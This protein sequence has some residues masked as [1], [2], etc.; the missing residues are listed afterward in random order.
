MKNTLLSFGLAGIT[1]AL[2]SFTFIQKSDEVQEP[3]TK[4]HIKMMKMENGKKMELDTVLNNDDVFV[5][6]GDTINPI[7]HLKKVNPS[8]IDKME[9]FD[10]KV[11]HKDGNEKVMIINHKGGKGGEPMIWHM[12]SDEDMEILTEDNDSTGKRIVVRKR[13]K[14]GD[15]DQVFYFNN[16]DRSQFPP[17]PPMPPAPPV[18][19][20]RMMKM[21]HPGQ[22]INLNDP[23]II[24]FKKKAL[25]GGREKIEIIRKKSEAPEDMSFDFNFDNQL[26]PPPPPPP[27]PEMIRELENENQKM[28]VIEK[29]IKVDGKKGKEIKVEVGNEE[30]K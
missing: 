19:H 16:G 6:N 3:K 10:V 14:D 15:E 8:G 26:M 1:T 5:W 2:L 28:K 9:K 29:E 24:S 18:P 11:D 25:S 7:K 23:N 17:M 27:A 30:N 13:L 4:R 22:I 12:D 21:Q 20:M